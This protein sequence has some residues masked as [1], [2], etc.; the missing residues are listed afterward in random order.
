MKLEQEPNS[1]EELQLMGEVES[2]Q[3]ELKE[4]GKPVHEQFINM[5]VQ[6]LTS[7]PLA[8]RIRKWKIRKDQLQK[9]IGSP[10][11]ISGGPAIL[12]AVARTRDDLENQ[13]NAA[14]DVDDQKPPP[15]G[16]GVC[17]RRRG[18]AQM[19]PP[20]PAP[21]RKKA[22]PRYPYTKRDDGQPPEMAL[23]HVHFAQMSVD[24]LRENPALTNTDLIKRFNA[25]EFSRTYTSAIRG[26][27]SSGKAEIEWKSRRAPLRGG[28]GRSPVSGGSG[29]AGGRAASEK[30][31]EATNQR[32]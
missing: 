32:G 16:A 23:L 7:K 13:E 27:K 12:P 14:I 9:L 31:G 8:D 30:I 11:A 3:E 10:R 18:S 17:G 21:K 25:S 19:D 15:P 6:S 22:T 20:H 1:D 26:Q 4:A 28:R 2:L 29:L 5:F 24:L